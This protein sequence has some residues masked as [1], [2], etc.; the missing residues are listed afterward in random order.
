MIGTSRLSRSFFGDA[1]STGASPLRGTFGD[2]SCRSPVTPR[3]PIL[4][5]AEGGTQQPKKLFVDRD[6]S[7][8]GS[9]RTTTR[10]LTPS[11]LAVASDHG[12]AQ[13]ASKSSVAQEEIG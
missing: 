9:Y 3:R 7:R 6:V 1:I 8:Y 11:L 5:V 10:Q 13:H 4:H 12:P 2:I